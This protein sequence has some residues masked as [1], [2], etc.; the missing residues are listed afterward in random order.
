LL[1]GRRWRVQRDQVLA[2]V[3]PATLDETGGA[4]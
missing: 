3:R 4:A 1:N 2:L